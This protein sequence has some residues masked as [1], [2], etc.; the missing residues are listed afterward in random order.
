MGLF[1]WVFR[2]SGPAQFL[3]DLEKGRVKIPDSAVREALE[4]VECNKAMS[5]EEQGIRDHELR[6]MEKENNRFF[7]RYRSPSDLP[8]NWRGPNSD[9]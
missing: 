9:R 5:P 1:R 6:E 2:K 8:K 4:E 3:E 7:R